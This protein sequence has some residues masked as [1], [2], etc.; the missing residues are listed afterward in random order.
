MR[1][2][3]L[4]VFV[5]SL[6]A[7]AKHSGVAIA[8]DPSAAAISRVATGLRPD[9][10]VKGASVTTFA[11]ADRMAH[12][13][14]PGVSIAV[15]NDGRI[16][17]SQGF[18]VREAGTT[19]AVSPTTLFQAASIS[20]PVAATAMLGLVEQNRLA[21]DT[22]VNQYLKSWR[23]PDNSFT[24]TEKVTLRRLVLH[25]AGF[26][27]HGF[28]GYASDDTV[29]TVPQILDG[30]KPANT[31]AVRVESVPGSAFS[32]SG[33]GITIEQLAMT[34]VTGESFPALMRR[35]VFDPIGMTESAYEQPLSNAKASRA[36][37][38]HRPDGTRVTGR[39]HTYPE[40]AAAGL[41]TTPTDLLKWAMAITNARAG[42]PHS[43][44]SKQ[45]ATEM[46]TVQ[47]EPA[48]LGPMLHGAGRAF[49]FEHGGSNEGYIC[50]VI[51]FPELGRG[52]AIMTNSDAGAGVQ[53]EILYA[54]AKE[55]GW[56]DYGPREIQPI[57]LDSATVNQLVGE[58]PVP[59]SLT[60]GK[61]ASQ[62][63]RREGG[64]LSVEVAGFVPK[65][66]IVALA[67]G[68]LLAPETGF[69]FR[70]VRDAS[71]RVIALDIGSAR[72]TKKP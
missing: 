39:W 3:T 71:G 5:A 13:K 48:G 17:W 45:S 26:G 38:D 11:L 14:V 9:F 66:V 51:Y 7:C 37:A 33:G 31:S 57:A 24:A 23:V 15:V 65:T 53:K 30:T 22:P 43:I 16:V 8:P 52:A 19:S 29:P 4:S 6:T 34:D 12:Y 20:K 70:M 18:G 60:G 59:V 32:Y 28:P 63:I 27:V 36:A 64:A 35:L 44:L 67:D 21:L 68:V 47:K 55:Y 40:L 72:L 25:S 61:E 69:E 2:T 46:L 50:Q 58:Y 62:F 1:I 56:P 10:V 41:W 42:M 49:Y 54:I